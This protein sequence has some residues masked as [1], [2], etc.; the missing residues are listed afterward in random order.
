M[1]H[2]CLILD[3][4]EVTI[5]ERTLFAP[6]VQIYTATH[7]TCPVKRRTTE[8][9]KPIKI[10]KDCWIG[11]NAVICPGVT[12]GDGVTIGAGAVVTRDIESFSVAVG[13]P[14]RVIKKLEKP[15]NFDID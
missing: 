10:G 3:V 9:G 1:N 2:N 12:I 7:P 6:G 13:N 5:G 8:Y 14:A 11:G 15:E 4:C